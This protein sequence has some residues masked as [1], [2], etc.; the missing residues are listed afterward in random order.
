MG[1]VLAQKHADAIVLTACEAA[2]ITVNIKTGQRLPTLEE[3]KL[4][5]PILP[6]RMLQYS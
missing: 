5:Y 3:E 4:K 1:L 2:M 6:K